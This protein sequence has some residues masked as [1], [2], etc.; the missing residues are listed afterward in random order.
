LVDILKAIGLFLKRL[1]DKLVDYAER[2]RVLLEALD[3]HSP[4]WRQLPEA[5]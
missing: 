1:G 4:Q 2:L 5:Q 3:T